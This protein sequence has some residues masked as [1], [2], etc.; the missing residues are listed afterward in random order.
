MR[1]L[2][3]SRPALWINTVGVAVVG[4]WLTGRLWSWDPAFLVTLLWLTLPFNLLIYGLNDVFDQAEDARNPRKGGLQ[5]ARIRADEVPGILWGV[6]LLN[7]PFVAFAAWR[8]EAGALLWMALTAG[9]FVA[10]SWPPLRFKAR[11]FWDSL[12]NVAYAL[13][14]GLIPALFGE[15][16]NGWALAGLMA[17]SVAKHAFDAVQDISADHRAGTRTIAVVL[18][19]RGTALWCLGWFALAAA[20][21]APLSPLVSLAVLL[22]SGGLSLRLLRAPLEA[23]AARLYPASILSP[24]LIGSVAGVQ[25]VALL[26]SGGRIG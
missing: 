7:L 13:P 1:L 20:L 12:S 22:V 25:L 16:P 11:P 14:L 9:L 18:G 4:L 17:W 26:V 19:P 6:A 3:I 21:F 5:G 23:Q 8:L 2:W 15:T 10:Y 24:W